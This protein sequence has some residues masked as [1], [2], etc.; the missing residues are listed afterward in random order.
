MTAGRRW[1]IRLTAAAERDLEIIL[2]WTAGQF[3]HAPARIYGKTL[4]RAIQALAEGPPTLPTAQAHERPLACERALHGAVDTLAGCES[5]RPWQ[6]VRCGAEAPTPRHRGD[7]T[8]HD[9]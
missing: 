7:E 4:T 1:R 9:D 2:R 3:G 5:R 8:R 6:K